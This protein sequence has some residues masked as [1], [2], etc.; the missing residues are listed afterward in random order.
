MR[1]EAREIRPYSTP[2]ADEALVVGA[3]YFALHFLDEEMLLPV[4]EPDV[5]V[6]RNLRPTDGAQFYFQDAASY[7]EGAR[8]DRSAE[9]VGGALVPVFQAGTFREQ[10]YEFAEA[11]EA[12]LACSLRRQARTS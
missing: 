10:V 3:T 12:L 1:F 6:G 4:L 9:S 7:R 5:Y 8:W 2:V 11:F